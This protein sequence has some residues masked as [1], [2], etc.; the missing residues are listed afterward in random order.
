MIY[1]I[2]HHRW[3]LSTEELS[4]LPILCCSPWELDELMKREDFNPTYF[5]QDKVIT[6]PDE[7]GHTVSARWVAPGYYFNEIMKELDAL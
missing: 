3:V 7:M 6:V 1:N 5:Y 2:D 4:R